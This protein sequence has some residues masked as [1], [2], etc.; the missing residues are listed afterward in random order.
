MM[1]VLAVFLQTTETGINA[2][3]QITAADSSDEKK[4]LM[5]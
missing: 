5:V 1:L 4:L 3:I 2:K